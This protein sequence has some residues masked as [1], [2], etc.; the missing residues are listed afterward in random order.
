MRMR[1]RRM[2]SRVISVRWGARRHFDLDAELLRQLRRLDDER[3]PISNGVIAH[4][5]S[6]PPESGSD[7]GGVI[8]VSSAMTRR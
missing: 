7:R 3:H 4:T 8:A 1:R 2:R 5:R 6:P